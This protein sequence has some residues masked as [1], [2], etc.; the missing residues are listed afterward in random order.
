MGNA[1]TRALVWLAILLAC[2][3]CAFALDPSLDV[4]QYAHTAWKIRDGFTKGTIISIAQT[5]DGYLW[6]GTEF[7]LVRFDGARAVPWQPPGDQHLPA[8]RIFSLL[9]ARDGTLWIG[10]KGLASWK[11]G[12]LTQYPELANQYVFKLLEDREG[13]V[14]I[15]T[16]GI[17]VGRLC[18]IRKG[19]VHCFGDDGRL[20]RAV[21][22]LYEDG[23]GNLWVGVTD[24]LWR[25]KPGPPK[26][27]S[28]P[29]E[30]NGIQAI[31][32]DIDGTLLVGWKG[33]IYRFVDG[34]AEAYSLGGHSRQFRADRI[35]RDRNGGLWIGTFDQGLVHVHQ[36]R[37]DLFS[38]TEGL[39]GEV[40]STLFEDRE[41][42]IWISTVEGLDRFRDFAV[43]TLTVKQGLSRNLVWSVLADKDG[44]V[45]FATYGGLNRWNH[46]PIMIPSTGSTKVDGKLNGF[47]AQSLF[48]DDRGRI[49]IPTASELGYLEDGR[50]TAIKGVP[51]G[52]M[53]S[54]AEDNARNLWVSTQNAGLFR[55]SPQNEVRQ[56]P[57]S[58]FGHKDNATVL[59]ADRRQGG[60]WIG[61]FLGGLA[62]LSDGKVLAS[63][64]A[65]DGLGPGRVSDLRFDDDGTL[66]VSTEG[67]LSRL[68]NNRVATLT[69]RNG[70]PCDT[71]HWAMEDDDHS[72]WLYMACGLVRIAR[73]E[74]DAWAAAVDKTQDTS[75]P[76]R[77]TVFDSSDG[78]RS[79][80]AP[81]NYHPQ[82]AKST[83][84]RLWFL[85]S[86]GVSVIEP[87][88]LAFNK[89]PPPVQIEQITADDKTYWQNW[90]GNA[91]SSKPKLPPLVRNLLIDYTALSLVVPEKVR[92]RFKLEGQDKDWREVVNDRRV[93][94][95]NLPPRNYRFRVMASNNSGV[96]NEQ[97]ASL[98]FTIAPAY[99]QTDWFRALCA[100]AF[101][102]LLWAAYQMRVH[103]LQEQENKFRDA[104]ETMPALAFVEDPNG[105]RTFFNRGWL[106]YTGLSSEQ[107]SGSVWEKA[108]H[109]D[110]LKRVTERW[111]KSQMTGEPL[112][113]E[114]RLRRGSDGVYRWFQ[115][116]ARPLRDSRGK[117]VKWCAV[118]TDIQD[119]K[120][121]EELQAELAHTNRVSTLGELAASISHELKQPICAAV[122]CAQASLRWLNRD[123]P[124]LDEARRAT[125][126]SVKDGV[127]AANIID[128]LGSLYKK[129]PP[130]RESVDVDEIIGEMVLLLRGE[131]NR[132]AISIR[133]NLAADLPKITADRVQLQQ[134]L[135]NL[136]L[137]GIEAM[138]E[139][140]GVLTVKTEPGEGGQVLISVSDT[141]VGLPA[142][143]AEEIFNAFF[144]TKPQGTGM[145]LAIS[146]SIIESHTGRLWA[147]P[148]DGRG[149]T[150]HFTLPIATEE[151]K[152]PAAET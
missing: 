119:R 17:P 88:H 86:D 98:D 78:V 84:G 32:E 152:V 52:N 3:G 148:N 133:T 50:F 77:V 20:G 76:I 41:G 51:G 136:M 85:P 44:S 102:A 87:R 150:F 113:Y 138:K 127:R 130:Q 45:W 53:P 93:E 105:N 56:I 122:T 11:D 64:T 40:V 137:N 124:D 35:L 19:S 70:L 2:S 81:G 143:R 4:S 24:G 114:A 82:V 95:S 6:L 46:G 75:F 126:E 62:Y 39:S 110:D 118:A 90:S 16:W 66:W 111:R 29:G 54:I 79:L 147:T 141:G 33:G 57:W 7:G 63:Y 94:Y 99:W 101:L 117:I 71:V 135:M 112:D 149:A 128:R 21:V 151:L 47:Y 145:G 8:G 60:L 115:T 108:V 107:A 125:A 43:A 91:S 89:L 109:P 59:A 15:G 55:I 67:G 25:W 22:G 14:W 121:A 92:F 58:G 120:R 140:G 131:A 144:T 72:V 1:S 123:Q 36:G 97:G 73:S 129:T 37:M 30:L 31:G 106:E 96:W 27:Y 9:A 49:W 28:L 139:A 18:A 23:R 48:Q 142:G 100:V 104:V 69:S 146:R 80:F 132:Y 12:K 34:K 5:P 116:R 42:N 74:L 38:P 26:F 83:D 134:V 65:A 68:K 13:T 10:A 103:Q 61:Y